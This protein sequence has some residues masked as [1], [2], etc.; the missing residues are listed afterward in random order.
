M[1]GATFSIEKKRAASVAR[2][3]EYDKIY[4]HPGKKS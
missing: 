3:E 4:S 2:L 1:M